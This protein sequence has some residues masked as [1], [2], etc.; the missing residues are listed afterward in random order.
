MLKNAK[1]KIFY[2]MH[3]Y[4]G[5]AEYQEPNKDSYR[6]FLNEDTIRSM[7]PT[8]AGRPVF[9]MHVDQVE[10]SLD[11]LRGEADGWVVESFYNQADGK[12]WVKFIA[13]SEKAETAIRNGMRLSNCYLPK[14]FAQGGLWNGV[15]YAKEITG[16]EYEHLAIVP[17]PR[18]EESVIMSPEEFKKYNEDK[19]VELKR[20]SN[21]NQG[22]DSGMKL[23][24]FKKAKV[25]NSVDIETLSVVLPNSGREVTISQLVAMADKKKNDTPPSS[26]P[27]LDPKGVESIKKAF[28]NEEDEEKDMNAGMADPAHKV[29]M[30]DGSYC[31]VAELVEKHKAL[32]DELEGMK[33]KKDDAKEGESE[34]EM[35][36]ES[37]DVEGDN[38]SKNDENVDLAKGKTPSSVGNDESDVKADD[39]DEEKEVE[40]A[41]RKN[42]KE[43]SDKLRNADKVPTQVAVVDL[44]MDRVARGVARYGSAKK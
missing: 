9:V 39:D 31:N 42:A 20:L 26:P 16:G 15:A 35:E 32:H 40:V 12:H 22:K 17:N 28:G 6:V 43:K 13:V 21:D 29:K 27:K 33:E 1:G 4:P 11:V 18:Y 14:S 2:G 7:D 3:F 36:K 41:K 34:L 19:F 10:K 23:N 37:V 25:D 38:K 30:H 44:S 24:F 8:F 5:V